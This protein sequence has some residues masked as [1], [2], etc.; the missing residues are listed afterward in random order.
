MEGNINKKL[1]DLSDNTEKW[2]E[3]LGIN[4][5]QQYFLNKDE[6]EK[7]SPDQ[8]AQKAIVLANFAFHVQKNY[9]IE[10][11][12]F[13]WAESNIK[14]AVAKQLNQYNAYSFEERK[15]LAIADNEYAQNLQNMQIEAKYRMDRLSYWSARIEFYTKMISEY[16]RTKVYQWKTV[17]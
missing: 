6:L 12:K 4:R 14:I 17:Q 13:N 5:L 10:A 15:L 9:N 1:K 7:S 16:Q 3:N 11:A 2:L 8:L